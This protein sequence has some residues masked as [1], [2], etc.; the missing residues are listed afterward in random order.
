MS[1][2]PGIGVLRE[3]PLHADL[4][5]CL[6]RPGDRFEVPVEGFII[7]LVRSD[8]ELVE[9]QTGSFWPLRPKLERLL[10]RY[11]MRVVH[12]IPAE[13]QVVRADSRG[14]ILSRRRSPL[15]GRFLDVFEHLVSF[16]TLL[17]HPNLV[18]EVVLCREE[19]VRA[20]RPS[21][22]RDPGQRR[23]LAITDRWEIQRPEDAA[24]LLP[25]CAARPFSSQELALALG[26]S[27]A[28]AQRYL[29]C[30]RA[31]E[32][33]QSGGRRGRTPLYVR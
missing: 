31:L 10:D 26:C 33:V 11:R 15:K 19:H 24:A 17:S 4:K 9:V 7:D 13:R 22:R 27:R 8:G 12:P 29:Y 20:P 1:A 6:A 21:R 25:E 23:L 30:L 32:L 16:P 2:P 18:L 28:M 3:S 14:E 5:I